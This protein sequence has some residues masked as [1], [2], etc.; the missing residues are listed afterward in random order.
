MTGE[1]EFDS[2]D[3]AKVDA[4]G[5]LVIDPTSHIRLAAFE[6]NGGVRILRRS[7][8]YTDGITEYGVL[9]AGLLFVSYQNDPAYFE[10]LQTRLGAADALNEYIRHI[11][12][13]I[14]FI[15]P[16]PQEGSYLAQGLFS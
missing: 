1:D 15:P 6:N 14:F 10:L 9:D 12:S 5:E 3:F 8:N 13:A 16:A 11:G 7:Y 2:P 4:N